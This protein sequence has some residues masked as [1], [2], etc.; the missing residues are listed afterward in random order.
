MVFWNASQSKIIHLKKSFYA[1]QTFDPFLSLLYLSLPFP[2]SLS[3][4]PFLSV[5]LSL[6]LSIS[7]FPSFFLFS[8]IINFSLWDQMSALPTSLL[9]SV[10]LRH[11]FKYFKFG[12]LKKIFDKQSTFE[13][14]QFIFNPWFLMPLCIL[15]MY[16]LPIC[17]YVLTTFKTY[18]YVSTNKE[19]K[20]H[21]KQRRNE[22]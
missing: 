8:F 10:C 7:P 17:F 20:K 1:G 5:S 14:K 21:T 12:I 19:I 3:L 11:T 4:S 13:Y 16:F 22:G 6:Y 9:M 2:L 15:L 18:L